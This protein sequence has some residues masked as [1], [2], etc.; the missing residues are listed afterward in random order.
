MKA[1]HFTSQQ[2]LKLAID[3]F[4]NQFARLNNLDPELG[5]VTTITTD[6]TYQA[7]DLEVWYTT[8]LAPTTYDPRDQQED[9]RA[10]I[11]VKV[12]VNVTDAGLEE[13]IDRVMFQLQDVKLVA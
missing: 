5:L 4:I 12:P 10:C 3:L 2:S 7:C 13:I 8:R 11:T 6:R 9:E 1:I